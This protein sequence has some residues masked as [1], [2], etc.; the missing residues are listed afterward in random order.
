TALQCGIAETATIEDRAPNQ[1]CGF[2]ECPILDTDLFSFSVPDGEH[3]GVTVDNAA[4]F[5]DGFLAGRRLLD[6]T[7]FP[8]AGVCGDFNASPRGIFECG[9]L[10]AEGNPYRL[11]VGD[12]DQVVSGHARVSINFLDSTCAA[13]CPGD[14]NGNHAVSINELLKLV[15]IALGSTTEPA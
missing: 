10:S 3:I 11:E 7:G 1:N 13:E 2:V 5:D 15:N 6:R 4:P 8:V 12:V 14:C 9:P